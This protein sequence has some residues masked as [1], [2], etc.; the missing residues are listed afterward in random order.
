MPEQ[1]ASNGQFTESVSDE[2]ILFFFE[3]G[4]RPFYGT[5]EVAEEF[6][7]S[8]TQAKRRLESLSDA[9][10]LEE[11]RMSDRQIAWWH[12]RDLVVLRS[13]EEGY[14]AHDTAG[15][16]ASAGGTRPE[17]LRN[18]AEAIEVSEG[19]GTDDDA[20]AE[21]DGALDGDCGDGNPF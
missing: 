5:S 17:A 12:D 2:D 19:I 3:T 13:E 15:G 11:I 21:L 18:L 8:H 16:V 4:D 9:G 1:R 6:D 20:F 10:K 14:S 7:L